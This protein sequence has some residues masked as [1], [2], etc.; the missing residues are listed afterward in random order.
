MDGICQAEADAWNAN[1]ATLAFNA[2][3]GIGANPGWLDVGNA[4]G[5]ANWPTS[6][7]T[8]LPGTGV[9]WHSGINWVLVDTGAVELR[10]R[11]GEAGAGTKGVTKASD[12][13]Y[14]LAGHYAAGSA[15]MS[16]II[17]DDV[18]WFFGVDPNPANFPTQDDLQSTMLHEIGHVLGLGHFGT[19]DRGYIMAE[20]NI[21]GAT[22]RP[23]RAG[24]G[25]I[26][27]VIDP[28]AIHGIR[29]LYAVAVP[30][31]TSVFLLAMGLFAFLG[32]RQRR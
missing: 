15:A 21:A 14:P 12:P 29:D 11:F 9:A 25:G 20:Q 26:N 22:G 7:N 28:D 32:L 19:Y 18:N 10:I 8:S 3:N 13:N 30:E 4:S 1:V 16:V 17:D 31:P 2:F 6:D 24:L 27:H 5:P 23:N